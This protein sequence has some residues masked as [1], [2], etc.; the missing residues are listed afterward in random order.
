MTQ[1]SQD[2]ELSHR[3]K[4]AF[5]KIH[6][7][8]INRSTFT[9][10]L[11]I[12][13]ILNTKVYPSEDWSEIKVSTAIDLASQESDNQSLCYNINMRQKRGILILK[14]HSETDEIDFELDFLLSLTTSERF[15][16]MENKSKEM[17]HLLEQN[18][19]RRPA[20]IIKRK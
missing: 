13:E 18:G 17:L 3:T 9:D 12:I 5:Q 7:D 15:R 2:K 4:E 11:R 14:D 6:D 8:N 20:E 1:I 19:H 10:W 16:L